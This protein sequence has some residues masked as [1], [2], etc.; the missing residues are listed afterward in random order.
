MLYYAL[1]TQLYGSYTPFVWVQEGSCTIGVEQAAPD[2]TGYRNTYRVD[3]QSA[4][5]RTR[6]TQPFE[7][8]KGPFRMTSVMC[9]NVLPLEGQS[10]RGTCSQLHWAHVFLDSRRLLVPSATS[11]FLRYEPEGALFCGSCGKIRPVTPSELRTLSTGT[12][13]LPGQGWRDC[14]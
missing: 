13:T 14:L 12:A 4:W 2:S 1:N 8:C 5:G 7:S 10:V 3:R 6:N 9:F 11:K